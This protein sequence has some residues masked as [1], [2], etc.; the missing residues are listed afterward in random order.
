MAARPRNFRE[1]RPMH[2]ARN[3]PA[4]VIARGAGLGGLFF[5]VFAV[6][7]R[8]IAPGLL[9][10][11]AAQLAPFASIPICALSGAVPVIDAEPFEL[12]PVLA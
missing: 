8:W 5:E 7:I 10:P 12:N 3:S 1:D 4:S 9:A 6:P 2:P 11:V